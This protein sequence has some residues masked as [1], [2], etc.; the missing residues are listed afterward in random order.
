MEKKAVRIESST[1]NKELTIL[2]ENDVGT[3]ELG[4]ILT[5]SR[6]DGWY[7]VILR[8]EYGRYLETMKMADESK[9]EYKIFRS[10]IEH[11]FGNFEV[12]VIVDVEYRR[13]SIEI[14]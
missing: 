9:K 7:F 5:R 3:T 14:R 8:D 1:M 13:W 10:E 4:V 11:A 12:E 2:I 6:F